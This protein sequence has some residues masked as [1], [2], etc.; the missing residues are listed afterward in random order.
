MEKIFYLTQIP[1]LCLF[2]LWIYLTSKKKNTTHKAWIISM[3]LFHSRVVFVKHLQKTKTCYKIH[4]HISGD[5]IDITIHIS[6]SLFI[7]STHET[8]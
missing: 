5:T 6:S 3:N 7:D 4:P 1:I 8:I 2:L